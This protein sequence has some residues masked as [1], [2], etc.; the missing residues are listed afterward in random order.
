M[1]DSCVTALSVCNSDGLTIRP[2]TLRACALDPLDDH[3]LAMAFSVAG[4]G[5]GGV[6]ILNPECVGKS[7]PEFFE[8]LDRIAS[9]N[10]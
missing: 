10:Q 6:E 1:E 4:L 9:R 5:I 7:Y 2:G 3:R 8:T